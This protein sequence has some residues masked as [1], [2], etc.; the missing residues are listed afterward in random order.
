MEDF[1]D[2]WA[3]R[4]VELSGGAVDGAAA[5]ALVTEIYNAAA[6][7]HEEEYAELE[8]EREE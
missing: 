7:L 2:I 1:I 8:A 4:L 3:R 5:R 6:G